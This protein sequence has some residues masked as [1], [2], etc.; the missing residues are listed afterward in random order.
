MKAHP[1]HENR[2]NGLH[3]NLLLGEKFSLKMGDEE[4]II[5]VAETRRSATK[6]IIH[7]SKKVRIRGP[8]WREEEEQNAR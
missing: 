8:H 7:A 1:E 3:L 5:F 2:V 4:I 6:V